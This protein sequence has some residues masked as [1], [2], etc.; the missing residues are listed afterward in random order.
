MK[1]F[2]DAIGLGTLRLSA[3]MIDVLQRQ[4]QLVLVMLRITAVLCA[5]IRQH[6]QQRNLKLFEERTL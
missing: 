2:T 1:T 3:R 6:A 4:V 5:P